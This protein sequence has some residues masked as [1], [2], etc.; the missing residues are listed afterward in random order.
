MGK[1]GRLRKIFFNGTNGAHGPLD[2]RSVGWFNGGHEKKGGRMT[3]EVDGALRALGVRCRFARC[4]HGLEKRG[5]ISE[6]GT[7]ENRS[8]SDQIGLV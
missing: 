4:R 7:P 2:E 3:D 6:Q 5:R 1:S 8:R